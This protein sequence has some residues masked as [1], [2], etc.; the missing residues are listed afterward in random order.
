LNRLFQSA[1]EVGKRVRTET[2]IGVRPVSAAFA[3]VKLAEQIFGNLADRT[4]IVLGAGAMGEQLVEYFRKRKLRRLLLANRSLDRACELAGRFQGEA[5]SWEKWQL[6]LEEADILVAGMEGEGVF[7]R[8][9]M[10]ETAMQARSGKPLFL[11]DLCLPRKID[12]QCRAINN[13]FLYNLD[14]LTG[15]VEA[16]KKAREREI[17]LV[18]AIISEQV[19]KFQ[20]WKA[21]AKQFAQSQQSLREASLEQGIS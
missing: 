5:V 2:Q 4:A 6:L 12:P 11:I 14:E 21:R 10:L 15:V 17:P 9:D 8:P 20:N 18:E 1:L 3:A 7:V 16:N 13:V 19:K